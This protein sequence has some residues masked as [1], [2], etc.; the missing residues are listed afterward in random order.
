MC[1]DF[2]VIAGFIRRQSGTFILARCQSINIPFESIKNDV[3]RIISAKIREYKKD[4]EAKGCQ[5]DGRIW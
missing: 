2:A 4:E 3:N 1:G 5:K